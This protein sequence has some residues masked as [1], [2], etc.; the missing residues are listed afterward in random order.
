MAHIV[1][2]S[3][4]LHH[5]G[6]YYPQ[7]DLMTDRVVPS[8]TKTVVGWSELP[9]AGAPHLAAATKH[10]TAAASFNIEWMCPVYEENSLIRP[11][12]N[13]MQIFR[14][15]LTWIP[16]GRGSSL[17]TKD[18]ALDRLKGEFVQTLEM[19]L[20]HGEQ[21]EY[22]GRRTMAGVRQLLGRA[23]RA[24]EDQLELRVLRAPVLIETQ[25]EDVYGGITYEWEIRAEVSL[26]V[27]GVP[28][29]GGLMWGEPK[30]ASQHYPGRAIDF[31]PRSRVFGVRVNDY[32][33]EARMGIKASDLKVGDRIRLV[34]RGKYNSTL[35]VVGE[36]YEVVAVK[37]YS[38][39]IADE[40]AISGRLNLH[41]SYSLRY[42]EKVAIVGLD[43]KLGDK[44]VIGADGWWG[45]KGDVVTVDRFDGKGFP[46]FSSRKWPR[47]QYN[48]S[49]TLRAMQL[50]PYV[51]PKPAPKVQVTKTIHTTVRVPCASGDGSTLVIN[52][53]PTGNVDGDG[54]CLDFEIVDATLPFNG[55]DIEDYGTLEHLAR[56]ITLLR[57]EFY[58]DSNK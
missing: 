49:D 54:P 39:D 38:V 41:D 58:R 35:L 22:G 34:Q 30:P 6:G 36:P 24:G 27:N 17:L 45:K 43:A 16:R 25:Y 19:T 46:V 48:D 55:I 13:H 44:F 56:Q 42:C 51:E 3:R 57:D 8:C 52:Y 47:G 20:E 7:T 31:N 33:K 11:V 53:D 1:S 32:T 5:N 21:F 37:P 40:A 10:V 9:M 15:S 18:E 2:S 50:T 12:R 4:L 14:H 26:K 28:V 29:P 23:F